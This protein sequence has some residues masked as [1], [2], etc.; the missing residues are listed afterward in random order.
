MP[1]KTKKLSS[2][3]LGK[4]GKL[5]AQLAKCKTKNCKQ[6]LD[7][8]NKLRKEI[9]KAVGWNS[10]GTKLNPKK[11]NTKKLNKYERLERINNKNLEE[12]VLAY[13]KK[14]FNEL[15]KLLKS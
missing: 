5:S 10:K 14:D 2:G 15:K 9:Y 7:K 11:R 13:C 3:K 8:S 1:K 6:Y 4:L 12:C